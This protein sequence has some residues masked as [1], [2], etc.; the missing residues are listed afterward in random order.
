MI[1]AGRR[2]AFSGCRRRAVLPG[3]KPVKLSLKLLFWSFSMAG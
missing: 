3:E 2:I 1:R